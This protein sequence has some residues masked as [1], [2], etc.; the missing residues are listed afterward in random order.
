MALKRSGVRSPSAP[1]YASSPAFSKIHFLK[2]GGTP[3]TIKMNSK[4]S[5]GSSSA[6]LSLSRDRILRTIGYTEILIGGIT[7]LGTAFSLL[8]SF[9]TKS[10]S[11]LGFVLMSGLVSLSL[12]VGILFHSLL[13]YRLLIYFSSVIVLSKFLLIA[14]VIRFNGSLETFIPSPVK[15]SISVVYHLF[16]IIY[17]SRSNVKRLFIKN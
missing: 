7:L 10:P 14:D 1:L 4:K 2:E 17:L 6:P 11:V 9:N 16:I 3:L 5:G 13:A 15:N 8:F 12:G